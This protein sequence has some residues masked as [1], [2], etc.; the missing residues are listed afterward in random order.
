[1]IKLSKVNVKY[2]K[3]KK[4]R[5]GCIQV[6]YGDGKGKTTA[7]MGQC[8][9]VAGYEHQILIYQFLKNNLSGERRILEVLPQVT[10]LKGKKEVKFSSKLTAQERAEYGIYYQKA[11][12]DILDLARCQDYQVIFLDEILTA[13][14]LGY[15]EE[16]TLV[17]LIDLC[18]GKKEVILT[19]HYLSPR[20]FDLADYVSHI[21]K[22]KHPF[23]AGLAA[24][25]GIEL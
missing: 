16:D 20:I 1:M 8:L 5:Y 19:G 4:M 3:V 2:R 11:M 13:I 18:R 6:Y 24:R 17:S 15:V 9:R 23:D 10:L 22:E 14:H 7:A 25:K 21:K 12:E